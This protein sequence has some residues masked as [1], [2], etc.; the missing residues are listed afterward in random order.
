MQNNLLSITEL[1]KLRKLTSETLRYYD[2]INLI[3]PNYV[4]PKTKY[5]YYSIRQ[6]EELGTI[7]ELRQL[8][9]PIE[10]VL[11]YFNNRSFKKSIEIF[12]EYQSRLNEE[13]KRKVQLENI[14]N[15]KIEFLK[16]L[17]SLPPVHTIT[18]HVF[19]DR[20]MITFDET[21]GGACEHAFAITK[22]ESHLN[23]IAPIVASDRIGA[24]GSDLILQK[25][26]NY[27]PLCPFILI[28]DGDVQSPFKKVIPGGLYLSMYYHG[29]GLERYHSSFELI[30][31]YIN[32]HDLTI[33]G[34]IYQTFK[35]DVTLTN[36]LKETLMEIQ[37]PVRK[38]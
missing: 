18:E 19:P 9:M 26:E 20:Y 17:N 13:I 32:K 7:R 21:A 31:E 33:N 15:K 35:I 11:D 14:L 1:A 37:V 5:R 12:N 8:G 6:Y 3:K 23:E 29:G 10:N 4:D 2:R 34:N 22:L 36:N 16:Q 28:E 38:L 27:I 25:S 30:K 24:Y